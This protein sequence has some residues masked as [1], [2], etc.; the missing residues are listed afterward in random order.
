MRR[1]S[2]F[3]LLTVFLFICCKVKT[4]PTLDSIKV[5]EELF[6]GVDATVVF[7]RFWIPHI[8]TKDIEDAIFV[9]G[10]ITARFRLFQIDAIRRIFRGRVAELIGDI[11]V[12]KSKDYVVYSVTREGRKIEEATYDYLKDLP[13]FVYL[14]KYADGVNA[15]INRMKNGLEKPPPEFK[16]LGVDN[17]VIYPF[18]VTDILSIIKFQSWFLTGENLLLSENFYTRVR[19]RF[20]SHKNLLELFVRSEPPQ[21]TFS[22]PLQTPPL[23]YSPNNFGSNNWVISAQNSENGYPLLANDP[24]LP[25]LNPP[26]WYALHIKTDNLELL[27]FSLV[28]IPGAMIAH[29]GKV[30][31]GIT[32]VGYDVLDIYKEETEEDSNCPSGFSYLF[33]GKSECFK[34]VEIQMPVRGKSPTPITVYLSER[35]GP[36]ITDIKSDSVL[37]IRWT[38]SELSKLTE[39]VNLFKAQT[40]DDAINSTKSVGNPAMNLVAADTQKN[41]AYAAYAYVPKREWNLYENPPYYVLPGTGCCEWSGWLPLDKLPQTKNP[42]SGFV[43]TANN[44]ILGTTA[45]NDPFNEGLYLLFAYDPGFRVGR[46]TQLIQEKLK[47]NQKLT[48]Q[49]M[50]N[51][52]NDTYSLLA[53][54]IFPFVIS[55]LE[56]N[57]NLFDDSEKKAFS[58][59][60]KWGKTSPSGYSYKEGELAYFE[61]TGQER[62]ESIAA[63]IFWTTFSRMLSN[64]FYDEFTSFGISYYLE[65]SA[66]NSLLYMLET[67]KSDFFD[68]IETLQV[69][70]PNDII[71]QSFREAISIL[72]NKESNI[73][74]WLWGMFHK[75]LIQH[76]SSPAGIPI[77]DLELY[78]NSG[79]DYTVNVSWTKFSDGA[80][81]NFISSGGP[82]IRTIFYV[83]DGKFHCLF[84]MPG[85]NLGFNPEYWNPPEKNDV[86][87]S[88]TNLDDSGVELLSMWLRGVYTKFPQDDIEIADRARYKIRMQ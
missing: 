75:T 84:S 67:G 57:Q 37:T 38:G 2:S 14:K 55:A 72:K 58:I 42:S 1:V 28:G 53:E 10:Y 78:P 80:N 30:S 7:D 88:L 4:E 69:E 23:F 5:N 73:D 46:I 6:L 85:S 18:E 62:E 16:F 60:K 59:L 54:R 25:L 43:A 19:T 71:F 61:T 11:A 33:D 34:K 45:D 22:L 48:V 65:D 39:L 40:V 15:F 56:K 87:R 9:Q 52:Q 20:S 47:S 17:P 32:N 13:E 68:K 36:V 8:F 24:H 86:I 79:V 81:A 77:F 66:V 74:K 82:S 70:G 76:A 27:G 31:W 35:H 49:D 44:D 3:L 29:N 41:I 64:T 21:K 26:I 51:F 12:E 63:S 50:Q 83:K